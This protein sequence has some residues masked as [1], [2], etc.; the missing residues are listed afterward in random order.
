MSFS[1]KLQNLRNGK[2][3]SQEELAEIMN[4][5]RQS[6]SK[7]EL[8]Q[9]FPEIEKLIDISNYFGVSVDSLVK[10]EKA[11]VE[12]EKTETKVS[13][14]ISEQN[15]K[16]PI[17]VKRKI[18]LALCIICNMICF[19]SISTLYLCNNRYEVISRGVMSVVG[20]IC[21]LIGLRKLKK[22]YGSI[23]DW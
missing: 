14:K 15:N 5:S 19:A 7:W 18:F 16:L 21:S 11:V 23:F 20:I 1:Q 4:V 22:K 2:N 3:L 10:D 8:G 17:G 13:E 6:V 12:N 9:S